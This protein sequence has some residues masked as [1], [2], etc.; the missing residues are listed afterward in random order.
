MAEQDKAVRDAMRGAVAEARRRAR[1]ATEVNHEVRD[2]ALGVLVANGMSMRQ[3]RRAVGLG[4]RER[5][6]ASAQMVGAA[7]RR[8]VEQ[9]EYR[10]RGPESGLMPPT[11]PDVLERHHA[12]S[13]A[14]QEIWMVASATPSPWHCE[15]ALLSQ[16][17]IARNR[18]PVPEDRADL[19]HDTFAAEFTNVMTGEKVL[20]YTVERWNGG[21]GK[22]GR[23]RYRIVR[24]DESGKPIP[25]SPVD[26]GLS[27]DADRFGSGW[28][29]PSDSSV[30]DTLI[31]AIE[32]HLGVVPDAVYATPASELRVTRRRRALLDMR[33]S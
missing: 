13:D 29:A 19:S 31:E 24:V 14:I 32:V 1:W 6:Q 21:P 28:P 8:W 4:R 5:I 20:V 18:C 17:V 25:Q 9:V 11:A 3:A 33:R 23:G 16:E 27:A 10:V 22:D 26:Y 7:L 2:K 12:V 30:L 15:R